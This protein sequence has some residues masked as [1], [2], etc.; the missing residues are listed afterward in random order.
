VLPWRSRARGSGGI[1][2]PLRRSWAGS[3]KKQSPRSL[4][5]GLGEYSLE[6]NSG[7]QNQARRLGTGSSGRLLL[8]GLLCLS[9]LGLLR[10]GCGLLRSTTGLLCEHR[11]GQR[12]GNGE[13]EQQCQ[14]L[15]HDR[16]RPPW[17]L[18]PLLFEQGVGHFRTIP[19]D[20]TKCLK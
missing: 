10:L 14:Q 4:A 20:T 17:K 12:E 6:S 13:R 15:L 19:L 5:R 2:P 16:S 7:Q 9:G 11:H 8:L 3:R 18:L 1:K